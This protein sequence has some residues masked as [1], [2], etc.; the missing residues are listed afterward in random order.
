MDYIIISTKRDNNPANFVHNYNDLNKLKM[1][2]IRDIIKKYGI[3][4]IHEERLFKKDLIYG[5]IQH[6]GM[7]VGCKQTELNLNVDGFSKSYFIETKNN[8]IKKHKVKKY[9]VKTVDNLELYY[10]YNYL[11]LDWKPLTEE[12][13]VESE[14]KNDKTRFIITDCICKDRLSLFNDMRRCHKAI[15]F[16]ESLNLFLKIKYLLPSFD[17]NNDIVTNMCNVYFN[18]SLRNVS[19]IR[20]KLQ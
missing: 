14:N 11:F 6:E 15:C 16:I 12:L 4:E 5:I 17:N 1:K 8:L 20:C 7:S 18:I 9:G 13:I 19:N 2:R 10:I 3:A